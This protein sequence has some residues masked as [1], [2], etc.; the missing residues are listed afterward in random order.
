MAFPTIKYELKEGEKLTQDELS[1]KEKRHNLGNCKKQIAT[2]LTGSFYM[3]PTVWVMKVLNS[4]SSGII[5]LYVQSVI[6]EKQYLRY[7]FNL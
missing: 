3:N 6:D 7:Q 4:D 5:E 1:K 2:M